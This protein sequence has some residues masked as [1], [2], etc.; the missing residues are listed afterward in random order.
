M[1]GKCFLLRSLKKKIKILQI[2]YN[3][4][5]KHII[6]SGKYHFKFIYIYIMNCRA[7]D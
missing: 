4:L 6:N 2:E 3:Y 5:E 1:E 7:I